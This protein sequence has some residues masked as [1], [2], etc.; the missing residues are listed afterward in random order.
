MLRH[1][2]SHLFLAIGHAFHALLVLH[3]KPLLQSCNN[4]GQIWREQF[5][6]FVFFGPGFSIRSLPVSKSFLILGSIGINHSQFIIFLVLFWSS[7]LLFIVPVSALN[8][9]NFS[10]SAYGCARVQ[11][12]LETDDWQEHILVSFGILFDLDCLTQDLLVFVVPRIV[13]V[14]VVEH[15]IDENTLV[16]WQRDQ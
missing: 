15:V 2:N 9:L 7:S 4:F 6:T 10:I 12:N 5:A 1:S 16:V 13:P 11:I 14:H 3:N 8:Y